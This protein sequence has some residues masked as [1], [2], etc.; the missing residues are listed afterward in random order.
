[1][2]SKNTEPYP[3]PVSEG[4][5]AVLSCSCLAKYRA[6]WSMGAVR[7]LVCAT[8]M[9]QVQGKC[10]REIEPSVFGKALPSAMRG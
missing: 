3:E 4:M 9:L 7:K 10:F 8:H 5:C 1:M 6:T 2:A